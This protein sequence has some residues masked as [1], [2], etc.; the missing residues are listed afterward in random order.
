MAPLTG[1]SR[2]VSVADGAFSHIGA[3]SC[4]DAGAEAAMNAA[5]DATVTT[6]ITTPTSANRDTETLLNPCSLI[7]PL[8]CRPWRQRKSLLLR[9]VCAR[10]AP[11]TSEV[12][13]ALGLLPNV[14]EM[15]CERS[16]AARSHC[17]TPPTYGRRHES[18]SA[19]CPDTLAISTPSSNR[20]QHINQGININ[21]VVI[22]RERNH[23]ATV[24]NSTNDTVA[25]QCV[26]C[27]FHAEFRVGERD[28]VG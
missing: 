5:S 19:A 7:I 14:S 13:R 24:A 3:D 18:R 10:N 11:T 26:C 6:A 23:N 20:S 28:Y 12:H 1:M 21:T 4:D 15:S 9:A 8:V 27:Y 16:E 25:T 2:P 22:G 17:S